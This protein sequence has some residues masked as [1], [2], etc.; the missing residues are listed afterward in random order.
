VFLEVN[1]KKILDEKSSVSCDKKYLIDK[2]LGTENWFQLV[3]KMKDPEKINK[4]LQD[5]KFIK[6]IVDN[7]SDKDILIYLNLINNIKSYGDKF[8]DENTSLLIDRIFSKIKLRQEE[9]IDYIESII[10]NSTILEF[11]NLYIDNFDSFD[12][13][14]NKIL[15][16][17]INK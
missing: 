17:F 16:N 12:K 3:L 11:I 1:I 6:Y 13:L 14:F 2:I 5:D 4:E 10:T 15:E 8:S 9:D 7:F